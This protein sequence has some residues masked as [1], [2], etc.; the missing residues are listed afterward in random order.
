M[1]FVLFHKK[2]KKGL[3]FN[4]YS[5]KRNKNMGFLLIYT[6]LKESPS[7]F[8]VIKFMTIQK[9]NNKNI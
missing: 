4:I 7:L 3:S 9:I 6:A 8:C 5:I 2:K 1:G